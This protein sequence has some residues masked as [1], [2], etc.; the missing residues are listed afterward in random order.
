MVSLSDV[1]DAKVK[2]VSGSTITIQGKVL[3]HN[4]E[5]ALLNEE[6]GRWGDNPDFVGMVGSGT[7][8][9]LS[10]KYSTVFSVDEAIDAIDFVL[11]REK[12]LG[13]TYVTVT[14]G[15]GKVNIAT[16]DEGLETNVIPDPLD[17]VGKLYKLSFEYNGTAQNRWLNS[18]HNNPSNETPHVVP[19]RSALIAIT[20]SNINDELDTG[21]EVHAAAEGSGASDTL[22]LD[23]P[24]TDVRVARKTDLG[25]IIFEAGDKVGVFLDDHGTSTRNPEV[26]LYLQII[27]SAL[28]DGSEQYS[29]SF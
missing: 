9:I 24:L 10:E 12:V 29:G 2:N 11:N 19:A 16:D 14:S 17:G 3:E 13:D 26:T 23:W 4:E 8:Q 5:Y 20:F 22:K 1:Q 6:K 7:L 15:A 25:S 18:S 21:V 27:E 28:E